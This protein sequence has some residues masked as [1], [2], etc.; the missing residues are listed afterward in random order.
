VRL[1]VKDARG[2]AQFVGESYISHTPAGSSLSLATGRA[3]DVKYQPILEKREKLTE[4]QW[5]ETTQY[6]IRKDGVTSTVAVD[7]KRNFWR[8]QMRYIFTNARPQAVT[9]EFTQNGLDTY[10]NDTRVSAESIKAESDSGWNERKWMVTIPANGRT[11]LT[12]Q[13]DTLN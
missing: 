5:T 13:Y 1:Y 8:T 10:S 7:V 3:F 2:Q 4:E 12:V 11:E 6:R 9:V